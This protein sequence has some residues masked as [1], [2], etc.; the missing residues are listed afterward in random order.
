MFKSM[1]RP[2]ET[3]GVRWVS[4]KGK[5]VIQCLLHFDCIYQMIINM[6]SEEVLPTVLVFLLTCRLT[7]GM[8]YVRHFSVEWKTFTYMSVYLIRYYSKAIV[9]KYLPLNITFIWR[10]GLFHVHCNPFISL[11]NHSYET[12]Y[13][14][15]YFIVEF[16]SIIYGIVIGIIPYPALDLWV[17]DYHVAIVG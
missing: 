17:G 11:G 7:H 6:V 1:G 14:R 5:W 9:R 2:H 4:L 12:F 8:L 16:I 3:N 13:R 15:I 10:L